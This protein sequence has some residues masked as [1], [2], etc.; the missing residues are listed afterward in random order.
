MNASI[1][2]TTK[3]PERLAGAEGNFYTSEK[4]SKLPGMNDRIRRLRKQSVETQESLSIERAL[5]TTRFYKEN[6]GKY[7]EAVMRA[8]HFLAKRRKKTIYI[9]AGELI[10]GERGPAPK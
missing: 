5:I 4:N 9:G 3:I 8:L 6:H 7:A 2:K 1:I 10:V